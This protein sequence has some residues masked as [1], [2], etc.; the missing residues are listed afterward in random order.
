MSGGLV[1]DHRQ[2]ELEDSQ[3]EEHEEKEYARE[4][5]RRSQAEQGRLASIIA[6][7]EKAFGF[8][9]LHALGRIIQGAR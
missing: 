4:R 1:G 8:T 2:E 3:V 7:E 9:D 6:A 5:P